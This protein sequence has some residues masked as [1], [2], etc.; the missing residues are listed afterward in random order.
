MPK[1]NLRIVRRTKNIPVLGICQ[2]CQMQFPA[3]YPLSGQ[4]EAQAAIQQQF[5]AHKC[6]PADSSKAAAPVAAKATEEK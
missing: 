6:E 1:R 3:R 4:G 5:N 2:F